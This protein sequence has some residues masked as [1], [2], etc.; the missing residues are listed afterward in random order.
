MF[1]Y[2]LTYITAVLISYYTGHFIMFLYTI[3]GPEL[4]FIPTTEWDISASRSAQ[5][6]TELPNCEN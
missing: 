3:G 5:H 4:I 6:A 2:I 1:L